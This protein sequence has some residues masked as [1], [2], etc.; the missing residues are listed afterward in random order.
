[1]ASS[2]RGKCLVAGTELRD[3]NFFKTVVLILEHASDG[4]MGLVVNRPSSL[5]VQNALAG[6]LDLPE[7]DE[8]VF[9]G[10]PVEPA[11]LFLLHNNNEVAADFDGPE[12]ILP[13][14]FVTNTADQFDAVLTSSQANLM[15]KVFSGYAG[16]GPSQL[17]AELARGDWLIADANY[18]TLFK[19]CAYELWDELRASVQKSH[20]MFSVDSPNPEWN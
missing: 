20:R 15:S 17:E 10:G 13:G 3:P 4:A 5:T 14:V 7:A 9:V 8:M 12:P 1:M 11:D 2:V 19:R 18:E 6:H 16:W